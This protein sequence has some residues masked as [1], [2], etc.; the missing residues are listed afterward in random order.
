MKNLIDFINSNN[1]RFI[2]EL[3][4]FLRIPSISNNPDHKP[5]MQSCS[6]WLAK[7]IESIG[8]EKVEV[9]NTPGHPIVYAEYMKAGKDKPTVLLYGHYDVQPVDPLELW[10][11][12]PFEPTI[13]DGKIFARGTTDDKGQLFIHLKSLE[14][15]L[16]NNNSLPVNIKILYEGEEEIGSPNL[17]K[18]LEDNKEL[19]KCNLVVISDTSMY[20]KGLPS[21]CYGLRGL[22]YM[23][24][25]LVGPNKD[26][27]SGSYGGGVDNPINALANLITKLKDEKGKILIDGFYDDVVPLSQ[28]E[29]DEFKRLP[30]NEENFKKEL[31]IDEVFGEEGYTTTERLSARPTLDCNGIWGGFQGEGAKTVLPSKAGAKISMRLVPNQM[32]KKIA[33]LFEAYINKIAPKSVKVKV[34]DLHGGKPSVTPIDTPAINA[35]VESLKKGFGVEPVFM[36]EGGS[37]PIVN[38]FKEILGADTVLLGFGLPD[39]NAHSPNEHLDLDNFHKGILSITHY[40]NELSKIK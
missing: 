34:T 7:H 29:R 21:I 17:P 13:K 18:F 23:Q 38:S 1:V 14:A 26:L 31:E 19:L 12:P 35:A 25:D 11:D 30:F 5:D 20:T 36:K 4:E 2:E 6:K 32:P 40:F 37:I 28:K 15:Y 22:A 3:K 9:Y 39:E 16:K 33:Q 8:F 10:T 27:H 24:I